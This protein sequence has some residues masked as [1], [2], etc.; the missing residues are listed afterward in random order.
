MYKALIYS[1][2]SMNG[3]HGKIGYIEFKLWRTRGTHGGG[4]YKLF[5]P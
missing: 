5:P 1:A 2:G 4:C 3:Q